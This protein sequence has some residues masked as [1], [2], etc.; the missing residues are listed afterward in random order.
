MIKLAK[1]AEPDI[2]RNHGADWTRALLEKIEKGEKPTA[3]EA[4]RYRH[5]E[6][7]AVIVE[8]THGKCAY[9]ESKLRHIH[10]GDV[11]HIYPKSLD[12]AMRFEWS[13]LTLACEICNQ[14]KSS[15]D[16]KA[17]HIIDPY[18]DDPD[19]HILFVGP[20]IFPRGTQQGQ[21]TTVLLD[22]NRAEL[23]ERRQEKLSQIM[24]SYN[25]VFQCDLPDATKKAILENIE[26]NDASS[27]AAYTAMARALMQQM[28]CR[29]PTELGEPA[30]CHS[31]TVASHSNNGTSADH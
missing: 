6:I 15:K 8:E 2:L 7:K 10:H 3:T 24:A 26:A 20:L 18:E 9:C 16:P 12:E 21:S 31:N 23:V 13:N 11:E 5:P 17:E 27:T 19:Q 14:R 28:A 29:L 30:A 25:S 1:L 4:S 22:L